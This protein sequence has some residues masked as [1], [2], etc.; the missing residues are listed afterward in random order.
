VVNQRNGDVIVLDESVVSEKQPR[1]LTPEQTERQA[2]RQLLED[3]SKWS[4][5]SKAE[6]KSQKGIATMVE[7][8]KRGADLGLTQGY[9]TSKSSGTK[10]TFTDSQK[11]TVKLE[12]IKKIAD[13][14]KSIWNGQNY[15]AQEGDGKLEFY[16]S[17]GDQIDA[18]S[19][20]YAKAYNEYVR[21]NA[22]DFDGGNESIDL[23][24][25][26][27]NAN[28]EVEAMETFVDKVIYNG[29]AFEIA[30]NWGAIKTIDENKGEWVLD[31][32][33][34]IANAVGALSLSEFS[35]LF[36]RNWLPKN[37][38]W[39][40]NSSSSIPLGRRISGWMDA[41]SEMKQFVAGM[42]E[43]DIRNAISEI[44]QQY[45]AGPQSV[46]ANQS[47]SAVSEAKK[48]FK[49]ITGLELTDAS[50]AQFAALAKDIENGT[51]DSDTYWSNLSNEQKQELTDEQERTFTPS[52][53]ANP[54]QQGTQQQPSKVSGAVAETSPASEE[55]ESVIA[56][57]DAVYEK[58][59]LN[60]KAS[61]AK[62]DAKYGAKAKQAVDINRNFDKYKDQLMDAG[63]IKKVKC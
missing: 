24:A 61:K 10:M 38:K 55:S 16:N 11:N 14:S 7:L 34:E 41:D 6:Q 13:D 51:F 30:E 12:T 36:D 32:T 4:K 50:A 20:E 18:R 60:F 43:S 59:G 19:K 1:V 37:S 46:P 22:S 58:K 53:K 25:V 49:K 45:P 47:S 54:A 17:E 26:F 40:D 56:E 31:P 28:D 52:E 62:F 33:K 35:S 8:K 44:I 48:E 27:E 39:I 57:M 23:G 9:E 3:A 2:K 63:I 29:N 21:D 5:S 15:S 42:D